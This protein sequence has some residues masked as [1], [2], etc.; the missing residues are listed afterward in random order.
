M[1]IALFWLLIFPNSP[2]LKWG[3]C[4]IY[5]HIPALGWYFLLSSVTKGSEKVELKNVMV[6]F[7]R[8]GRH[9]DMESLKVSLSFLKMETWRVGRC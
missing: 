2:L 3:I 7:D 4:H 1:L 6:V 8:G 5:V 9:K